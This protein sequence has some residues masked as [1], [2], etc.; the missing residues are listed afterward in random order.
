MAQQ[1]YASTNNIATA[2]T[3]VETTYPVEYGGGCL[4][5]T[6]IGQNELSYENRISTSNAVTADGSD[7]YAELQNFIALQCRVQPTGLSTVALTAPFAG[8]NGSTTF[9]FTAT[10]RSVML[11]LQQMLNAMLSQPNA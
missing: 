8:I 10:P 5:M 3:S 4:G 9:T 11:R 7:L 2:T 6:A 1:T